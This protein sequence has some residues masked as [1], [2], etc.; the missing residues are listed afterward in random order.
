[1]N[2]AESHLTFSTSALYTCGSMDFWR[3]DQGQ[4]VSEYA[5]L[6]S[7]LFLAICAMTLGHARA[8]HSIWRL[9]NTVLNWA[10]AA[11]AS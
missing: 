7:F 9:A 1:M 11:A 5:L 3:D 4:D 10:A 2:I 8:M 6:L